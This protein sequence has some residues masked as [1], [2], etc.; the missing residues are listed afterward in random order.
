MFSLDLAE[1]GLLAALTLIAVGQ[2]LTT[3]DERVTFG[4]KS[5][6]GSAADHRLLRLLDLAITR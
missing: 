1:Y 3:F 2:L 6:V 4:F 5:W